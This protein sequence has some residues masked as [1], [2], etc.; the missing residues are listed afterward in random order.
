MLFCLRGMAISSLY[1][2]TVAF[3]GHEWCMIIWQ[4]S[5]SA[6]ID[7][8][9]FC[10]SWYQFR[11]DKRFLEVNQ[12]LNARTLVVDS[13]GVRKSFRW[14]ARENWPS[15]FDFGGSA[16][17]LESGVH[18]DPNIRTR[19]V[20]RLRSLWSFVPYY[21]AILAQS[22]LWLCFTRPGTD[23]L[24]FHIYLA[25]F[26]LEFQKIWQFLEVSS[27][28][29]FILINGNFGVFC[30][31]THNFSSQ[32]HLTW[33]L[34]SAALRNGTQVEN[35]LPDATISFFACI[36]LLIYLAVCRN[37]QANTPLRCHSWLPV[38]WFTDTD[39]AELIMDN[40]RGH[41]HVKKCFLPHAPVSRVPLWSKKCS[42]LFSAVITLEDW[43]PLRRVIF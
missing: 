29:S 3:W 42:L 11:V 28:R 34:R 38:T 16:S 17:T 7:C 4:F 12:R 24:K 22:A 20:P 1:H 10:I 43:F 32:R 19:T 31:F 41:Q 37:L 39:Q 40:V 26:W 30:Y 15:V 27:S 21:D 23:L 5:P 25:R 2:K 13:G 35:L 36:F 33:P 14:T 9:K 6:F 8:K 18:Y